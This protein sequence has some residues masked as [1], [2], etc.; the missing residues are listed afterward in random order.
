M[1]NYLWCNEVS[2][3]PYTP[4]LGRAQ[5]IWPPPC[6]SSKWSAVCRAISKF[7]ANSGSLL[8]APVLFRFQASIN[9]SLN[10][11]N[12]SVSAYMG[13]YTPRASPSVYKF[14]YTPLPQCL[15]YIETTAWIKWHFI[16]NIRSEDLKV[17]FNWL[18]MIM[19]IEDTFK[20]R[21]FYRLNSSTIA[22]PKNV[23]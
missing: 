12:T 15:T 21:K 1:N 20:S 23:Y 19:S 5:K 7:C 9:H 16:F 22:F 3:F 11:L 13:I 4:V 10:R 17:A 18:S 14:P 8:G 6:T 2:K